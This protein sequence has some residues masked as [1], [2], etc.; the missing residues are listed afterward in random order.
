[1]KL[2]FALIRF[3]FVQSR[4]D[5]SLRVYQSLKIHLNSRILITYE[6]HIFPPLVPC[7]CRR[8]KTEKAIVLRIDL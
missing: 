2:S 4:R 3:V 7:F 8:E 1:M 6:A 5:R